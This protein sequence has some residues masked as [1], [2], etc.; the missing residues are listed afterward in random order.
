MREIVLSC[1]L[2]APVDRVWVEV[3]KPDLL[4]FVASPVLEFRP[5]VPEQFPEEWEVG[6]YIVSMR[7][8]GLVPLGRQTISISHPKAPEGCKQLRDNGHSA[9]IRRWDHLITLEPDG[10]GTTYTDRVTI[11]AGAL[12]V[13]VAMFAQS[14]YAHRQQRWRQLV[15]AEFNYGAV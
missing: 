2:N 7:W 8:R 14:F 9:L 12:T 11:D 10:A 5:A 6:D 1:H 13:P 15:D 4:V 3:Q